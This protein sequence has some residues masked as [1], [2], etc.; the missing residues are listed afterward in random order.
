[1]NQGSRGETRLGDQGG[2]RCGDGTG[3]QQQQHQQQVC[4]CCDADLGMPWPSL[5][6]YVAFGRRRAWWRW[7]AGWQL[8]LRG[9]GQGHGTS[10]REWARSQLDHSMASAREWARARAAGRRAPWRRPGNNGPTVHGDGPRAAGHGPQIRQSR[11]E[12]ERHKKRTLF[13]CDGFTGHG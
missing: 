10:A 1:M 7:A 13:P 5:V 3:P 2:G 6:C 8:L 4:S 9:D 11:T 12:E